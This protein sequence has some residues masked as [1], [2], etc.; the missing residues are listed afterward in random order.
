MHSLETH[1]VSACLWGN[2]SFSPKLA[3]ISTSWRCTLFLVPDDVLF[4]DRLHLELALR[5]S[6]PVRVYV[7]AH[8]NPGKFC[9]VLNVPVDFRVGR[10]HHISMSSAHK[11]YVCPMWREE[12]LT[13]RWCHWHGCQELKPESANGTFRGLQMWHMYTDGTNKET[14]VRSFGVRGLGPAWQRTPVYNQRT[15]P[16]KTVFDVWRDPRSCSR[17]RGPHRGLISTSWSQSGSA[18]RDRRHIPQPQ[19]SDF[20]RCFQQPTWQRPEMTSEWVYWN[21][22]ISWDFIF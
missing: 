11:R 16:K 14:D 18:C 5:V 4:S 21:V 13:R 8:V 1:S 9:Q 20:S 7:R 10:S 2:L 19:K 17:W 3:I 22:L 15:P 6:V 12:M